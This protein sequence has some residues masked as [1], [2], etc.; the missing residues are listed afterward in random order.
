MLKVTAC[1]QPPPSAVKR[2]RQRRE[3]EVQQ[4]EAQR[5]AIRGMKMGARDRSYLVRDGEIDVLRNVYGGVEVCLP[6]CLPAERLQCL[7]LC[8]AR[9]ISVRQH[10]H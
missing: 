5:E 8:D 2:E 9:G 6:R 4:R 10:V 7:P 3:Q 1:L